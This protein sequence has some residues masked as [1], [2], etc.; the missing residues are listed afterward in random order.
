M[1]GFRKM[2][3]I[4]NKY[5]NFIRLCKPNPDAEVIW[6]HFPFVIN[7]NAPFNRRDLQKFLTTY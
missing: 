7:E 2:E 5:Q 3:E 4:F 6:M 1:Q